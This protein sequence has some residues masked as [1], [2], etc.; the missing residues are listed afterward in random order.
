M[1]NQ[2]YVAFARATWRAYA[3][4]HSMLKARARILMPFVNMACWGSL[5]AGSVTANPA[6]D[7]ALALQLTHVMAQFTLRQRTQEDQGGEYLR[8]AQPQPVGFATAVA[9]AA[10]ENVPQ[11]SANGSSSNL[12]D[13][14]QFVPHP[15]LVQSPYH[16]GVAVPQ[17]EAQLNQRAILAWA[18]A[19]ASSAPCQCI[20]RTLLGSS[21]CPPPTLAPT[22][23]PHWAVSLPPAAAQHFRLPAATAAAT[24]ETLTTTFSQYSSFLLE[25]DGTHCTM[26]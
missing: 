21:L 25:L 1:E 22:N 18:T 12:V 4:M 13:L 16:H 23:S 20:D 26:L 7:A 2:R 24:D 5:E 19:R 8:S 6:R 10:A 3:R 15:P 9:V 17:T 14:R 11:E